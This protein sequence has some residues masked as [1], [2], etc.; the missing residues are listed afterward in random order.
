MTNLC[1][2]IY[3]RDDSDVITTCQMRAAHAVVGTFI[4]F[5]AAQGIPGFL[6]NKKF[7]LIGLASGAA[8][9]SL[10]GSYLGYSTARRSSA[11]HYP[12]EFKL[13]SE[14]FVVSKYGVRGV[15]TGVILTFVVHRAIPPWNDSADVKAFLDGCFLGAIA[16]FVGT[17]YTANQITRCLQLSRY[18]DP[19]SEPLVLQI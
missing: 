12:D 3:R 7:Y 18:M 10:L 15:V 11:I 19:A 13:Y 16:S 9:G 1:L 4:L 2:P 17:W 5:L 14:C 6:Q 8:L